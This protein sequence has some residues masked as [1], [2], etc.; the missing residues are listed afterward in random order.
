[1][2]G[3]DMPQRPDE[4]DDAYERRV[5]IENMETDTAQKLHDIELSTKRFDLEQLRQGRQIFI[6]G[7][8]TGAAMLAALAGLAR[9]I[10]FHQ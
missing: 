1:M 6:A 8:A 10:W 2:K 7:L 5:R 3:W 9:L 4:S